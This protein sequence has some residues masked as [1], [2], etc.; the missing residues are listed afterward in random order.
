VL[1]FSEHVYKI[2][3]EMTHANVHVVE[4]LTIIITLDVEKVVDLY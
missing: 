3:A 2:I 1:A 4:S